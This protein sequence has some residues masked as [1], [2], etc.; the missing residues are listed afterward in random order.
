MPSV[1]LSPV[2]NIPQ[3]EDQNGKPL[4]GG[5]IF[6]YLAG[7]TSSNATTYTDASGTTPN[8]NPM[9]LDSSGRPPNAFWLDVNMY[10]KFV[11]TAA[12]GTTVLNTIDSITGIGLFSVPTVGTPI[13]DPF[14]S[15]IGYTTNGIPNYGQLGQYSIIEGDVSQQYIG[16][17]SIASAN[18]MQMPLYDP[19][20]VLLGYCFP[21]APAYV[22]LKVPVLGAFTVP[23]L[24][25]GQSETI[26][27]PT[28]TSSGTWIYTT[29]D[30]LVASI[31]GDIITAVSGGTVTITAFQQAISTYTSAETTAIFV[32]NGVPLPTPTPTPTPTPVPGETAIYD[33]TNTVIFYTYTTPPSG[34]YTQLFAD[35]GVTSLGY[36]LNTS[37][38]PATL[39]L[40]DPLSASIGY[41]VP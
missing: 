13:E 15:I 4:S 32:S 35:S 27:P 40:Q 26:T 18:G 21:A 22:Q 39:L 12:D 6:T 41:A 28:S 29:S 30:P 25:A 20:N 36:V 31:S 37:T 34:S 33:I 11:L 3:F 19:L 24:N 7:S 1:S 38:S 16:W 14:G 2:Y 5:K 23:A 17:L 9:I 10:Y 8:A